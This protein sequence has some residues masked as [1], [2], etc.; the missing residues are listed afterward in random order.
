MY[1]VL[2]FKIIG[3]FSFWFGIMSGKLVVDLFYFM[4]SLFIEWGIFEYYLY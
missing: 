3:I 4:V 2:N 1:Y